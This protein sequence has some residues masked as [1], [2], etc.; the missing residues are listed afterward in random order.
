M[1]RFGSA[2]RTLPMLKTL[3]WKP[4]A[5]VEWTWTFL[6]D[7]ERIKFKENAVITYT[8]GPNGDIPDNAVV[9]N[10]PLPSA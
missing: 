6:R 7:G 8:K 1:K 5:E 2:A 10:P 4:T 3:V 9:M